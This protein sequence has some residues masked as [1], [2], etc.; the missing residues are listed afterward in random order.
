MDKSNTQQPEKSIVP[1]ELRIVL[2]ITR[3]LEDAGIRVIGTSTHCGDPHPYIL[4]SSSFES[5]RKWVQRKNLKVQAER[6]EDNLLS[7][8]VWTEYRGVQIST[9]LTDAEKERYDHAEDET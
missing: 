5:F 9:F 4:F 3:L 2:L 8:I 7:W 1:E 6:Y